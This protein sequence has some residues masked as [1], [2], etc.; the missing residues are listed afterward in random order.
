MNDS[1]FSVGTVVKIDIRFSNELGIIYEVYDRGSYKEFGQGDKGYSVI[2]E[3]GHDLGGF[4]QEEADVYLAPVKQTSLDYN[5]HSVT[6]LH[7]DF[8]TKI[9]PAFYE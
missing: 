5:F 6:Q 3:S 9:Q 4:S 1:N 2:T 8:K 7:R